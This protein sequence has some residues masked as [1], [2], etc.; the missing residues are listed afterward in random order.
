MLT[1]LSSTTARTPPAPSEPD[2]DAPLAEVIDLGAHRA[3]RRRAPASP[4]LHITP[5]LL[6]ALGG[7]WDR[8]E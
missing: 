8:P 6:A 7:S 5:A 2:R 1:S 3:Q 4:D